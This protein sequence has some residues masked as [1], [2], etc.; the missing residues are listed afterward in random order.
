MVFSGLV[1]EGAADRR[2]LPRDHDHRRPRTG[3]AARLLEAEGMPPVPDKA[4]TG[5]FFGR[6][7]MEFQNG[8]LASNTGGG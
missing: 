1:A 6:R 5:R 2:A 4:R 3:P 7:V 8:T